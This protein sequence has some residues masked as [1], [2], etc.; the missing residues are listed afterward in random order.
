MLE[1]GSY[2]VTD[3]DGRYH[4]EGVTPGTHVVQ[5]DDM[6]LPA[7]RAAADCAR[8]SRSAGRA[9]SRF[10]DGRGGALKRVD[11]KL[12]AGRAARRSR[13]RGRR[14][15]PAPTSD[16]AAAGAERDWL[17]G[18]EPGIAWL[19]PEPE[20]NPRAPIVRVAIKHLPGQSVKLLAGGRAG[21]SDRL[22]RQ[23][24]ECGRNRRRQRVARRSRSR[25]ARPSSSPRCATPTAA[26][27]RPCAEPSATAPARCAPSCFATS[28]VLVADGVTRPVLRRP[29]HRP[30]RPPGPPRPDR[31]FRGARALLSRGRGRRPAGAPAR[32]PRARPPLLAGRGRGGH[33]LYRARADHRLGHGQPALQLPRRRGGSASSGSKPGS[34]RASGRG[35]SSASPRERSATTGCRARSRISARTTTSCSPTAGSRSTP[36]AGSA[37]NG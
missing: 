23:P 11:F 30:R 36:R 28:R 1:D 20:H 10:V 22:R 6:T 13:G 29:P 9:F 35:R 21:R 33:R 24:Q 3:R 12:V 16:A 26:S 19:F 34:I 27:P 4:F 17:A 18:E 32:R 2:A 7:D 14:P 31:R 15:R 25:A 37:A 5:L 8:N